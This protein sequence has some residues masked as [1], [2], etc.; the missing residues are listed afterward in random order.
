VRFAI[1]RIA[2]ARQAV[3]RPDEAAAAS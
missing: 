1:N 3:N 2:E